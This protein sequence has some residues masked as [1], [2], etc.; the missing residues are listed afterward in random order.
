RL[1]IELAALEES[2][3]CTGCGVRIRR[4]KVV[5]VVFRPTVRKKEGVF[6]VLI[7]TLEPLLK[8]IFSCRVYY[9][10]QREEYVSGVEVV[11]PCLFGFGAVE[12]RAVRLL[13]VDD[14]TGRAFGEIYQFPFTG[15]IANTR[16]HL[17][18]K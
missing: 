9:A 16:K 8:F 7:A 18:G 14:V 4:I 13:V 12:P 3:N 1:V 5:I 2:Y 10:L 15:Y 17:C 11:D 6:P